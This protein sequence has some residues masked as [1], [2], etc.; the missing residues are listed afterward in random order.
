MK[1]RAV[2]EAEPQDQAGRYP[3]TVMI[4]QLAKEGKFVFQLGC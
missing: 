2:D 1:P 4:E 3:S